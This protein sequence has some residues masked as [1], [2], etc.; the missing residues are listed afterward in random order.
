MPSRRRVLATTGSLAAAATAGCLDFGADVDPGTD[1]GTD[2]PMPDF[3]SRAT[4]WARDA[5]APRE[6][7]SERFRI[8]LPSPTDR[9]VVADRTVFLPTMGGLIALDADDG[10]ER[11]RYAPSEAVPSVS[12]PAVHDGSVYVTGEDPG[13]VALDVADGSVEWTVKSDER[14]RA[15][16]APTR[17]WRALYVGDNA[18]RVIR[19]TPDGEVEWTTDVYGAVTRLV[20]RGPDGVFVGTTAGE[21]HALYDGRGIWRQPVPGKVTALAANEGNDVYV[22]TFGGGTLRLAGG[23]HAG[24]SRWHAEDGP[25]AHRSFALVGT[26]L[27]GADGAG[28]TRQH[29]RT[30]KRDWRL[31]DDY[32]SAPAAVGDTVYV[33]GRGEVAAFKVGGGLGIGSN[34]VEA[35]RWTYGLG[36]AAGGDLAVADGVLFVPIMGREDTESGLLALE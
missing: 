4:S 2:W 14:M 3:D 5:A 34:R 27:F 29:H 1:A 35:R 24:R 18:G 10:E 6:A 9:P 31:G 17:E 21:V 13:L 26:G 11:W 16:P 28:L 19:V 36:N 20:A 23:A 25:T 32:F 33:G 22:A 30:G 7:P 15:P 12:S 8:D